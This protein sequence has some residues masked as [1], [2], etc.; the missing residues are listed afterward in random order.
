L[1]N[2]VVLRNMPER[3]NCMYIRRLIMRTQGP[4]LLQMNGKFRLTVKFGHG[5]LGR[6]YGAESLLI[7]KY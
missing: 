1:K 6:N 2:N 4:F 7:M 3:I 5:K